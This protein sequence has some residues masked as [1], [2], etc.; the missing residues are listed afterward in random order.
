M[1]VEV[2]V[3][4]GQKWV[5]KDD[6]SQTVIVMAGDDLSWILADAKSVK[7]PFELTHR[8]LVDD[9]WILIWENGLRQDF[10]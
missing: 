7:H 2:D 4:A 9:Y 10:I 8:Q 1:E 6:P 3:Y 5:K